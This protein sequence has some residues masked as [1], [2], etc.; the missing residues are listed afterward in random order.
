MKTTKGSLEIHEGFLKM[1][2]KYDK[3]VIQ[4]I[5]VPSAKKI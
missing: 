5:N 1:A 4:N 2:E 3:K